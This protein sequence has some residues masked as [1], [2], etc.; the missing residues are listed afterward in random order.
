VESKVQDAPEFPQQYDMW[1]QQLQDG[2][3][4]SIY[5]NH[6]D[7]LRLYLA[8]DSIALPGQVWS[9]EDHEKLRDHILEDCPS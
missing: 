9:F 6:N 7:R 3:H 4:G 1:E 5:L 8:F 2:G